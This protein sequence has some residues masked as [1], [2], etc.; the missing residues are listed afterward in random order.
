[1]H[2][3]GRAVCSAACS[4][5][6]A[7]FA[8]F[9]LGLA[10]FLLYDLLRFLRSIC[11]SAGVTFALDVLWCLVAAFCCFTLYLGYTDGVIRMLCLWVCAGGFGCGYFTLGTLTSTLWASIQKRSVAKRKKRRKKREIRQEKMKKLLHSP[12]S[13]LYNISTTYQR[14]RKRKRHSA[15]T[16]AAKQR[17]VYYD[18]EFEELHERE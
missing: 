16:V 3:N 18:S 14:K 15:A 5:G 10:L 9:L 2:K 6:K 8:F 7:L 17:S 11:D 13:I 12:N 1:M 4:V